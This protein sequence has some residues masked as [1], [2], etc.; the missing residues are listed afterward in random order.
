MIKS[1]HIKSLSIKNKIVLIILFVTFLIISIGFAFIG[2]WD[3][4]RLKKEIQS[5]LVLN[6]KLV[7]INCIVP[8]TFGDDQ[9]A[10]EVLSQLNNIEFIEAGSLFDSQGTLFATYPDTLDRN[11]LVTPLDIDKKNMYHDGFFYVSETVY[12]QSKSYGTLTIK[13]NS[14]PLIEARRKA[15]IILSSLLIVLIF[16]SFI[17]ANMMQKYI[18][19]PII[20]LKNHFNK[21]ADNHDFSDLINKQN[22]DEVGS[23]YDGFNHMLKQINKE[24]EERDR[25]MNLLIE[26]EKHN[27]ILLDFS[28]LG[29]ALCKMDGSLVELNSAYADIIG[30]EVDETL[31]LSYWDIT[32][33]KYNDQEKIQLEK[34]KTTGRYGPYEKEYIHK[35]GSLIPVNLFGIILNKDGQQYIWSSVEDI[36]ERKKA[37]EEIYRLLEKSEK[38]GQVLLSVLEDEK[39]A[40]EEI[41]KLNDSLEFRVMERTLQLELANKELE[42]FSY[43]V[44][45]DLRAPLRHIN[46]YIDMLLIHF[47]DSL[48]KEGLRYIDTIADS[49]KQ[50]GKLI[51][52]LLLF[53]RTG[54]QV[55]NK[56]LSGMSDIF[57]KAMIAIKVDTEGRKIKWI[58]KSLPQVFCDTPLLIQVWINLLS[59]AVK[60]TSKIE[61]ALIEVGYEE[62]EKE[63][64][65]SVKDNGVGFDMKYSSKLFGVFQRLHLKSEYEGTGIGLANVQRIV[66][67]HGG[68]IWA[69][70]EQKK[71][72][73]FF[74]TLPKKITEEKQ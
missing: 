36:T 65:F 47:H 72:A 53:S 57:N 56:S 68:R 43:S 11:S 71:G 24:Q 21:I 62:N 3:N 70:A 34:L 39:I 66:L 9:H 59:N 50:M 60:F 67:R 45:H 5:S 23:L 10:E 37:E 63:Y 30:R 49:A 64:T 41:K 33:E 19:V 25:A 6:T 73:S 1:R 28:P 42:A 13:A 12:Y 40:R 61:K 14:H 69:D 15:I 16:L 58:V 46:G 7:A 74:F 38:S 22:N 32:P 8:L 31:K 20:R 18:S 48:P 52:D 35:N 51:D 29:L 4:N 54:K 44:S 17:L 2:F 26:S 27:R 55:M